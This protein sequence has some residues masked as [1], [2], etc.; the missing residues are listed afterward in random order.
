MNAE[1]PITTLFIDLDDTIYPTS[2]GLWPH[3]HERMLT[4]MHEM[5]GFSYE[6]IP[7][8]RDRL[9][10]TYGTTLRG[11]RI[12]YGINPD[13]FLDYVHDVDLTRILAP[14][15]T[16][17]QTL[18]A[19]PQPK[20]IFT[21]A[22]AGHA[23]NVLGVMELDDLFTGII[24][25]IRIDPYCKPEPQAYQIALQVSGSPDPRNCLFVDDRWQNLAAAREQGFAV[26]LVADEPRPGFLTIPRLADL[27]LVFPG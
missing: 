25:V 23:R 6:E 14:D 15:P 11:L 13:G 22:S 27:P 9:F 21:N 26:V 2:V 4:F 5:L 1:F 7:E 17:R 20:W 24:D 8:L 19:Y 16:L 10:Y 12:E 3:I 18:A